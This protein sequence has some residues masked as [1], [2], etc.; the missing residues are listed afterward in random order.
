MSID[1]THCSLPL[2]FVKSTYILCYIDQE[3]PLGLRLKIPTCIKFYLFINSL[4]MLVYLI[5]K[6]SVYRIIAIYSKEKS[7]IF[8]LRINLIKPIQFLSLLNY[9]YRQFI[10]EKHGKSQR[11][12]FKLSLAG[13][14]DNKY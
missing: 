6:I 10:L 11:H 14:S 13:N 1:R 3:I 4:L 12:P 5:S 8:Y 9:F 2:F 7:I